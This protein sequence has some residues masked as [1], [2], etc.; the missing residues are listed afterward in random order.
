MRHIFF[1]KNCNNSFA[2]IYVIQVLDE[3]NNHSLSALLISTSTLQTLISFAKST[4][5][6]T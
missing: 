5:S 1:S 3:G 4:E 2:D 6:L